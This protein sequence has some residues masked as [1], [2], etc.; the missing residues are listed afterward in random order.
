MPG[1]F[2]TTMRMIVIEDNPADVRLVREALK[3]SG[4]D[5]EVSHFPDGL[6]A[7]A[8]LQSG[9]Q[10]WSPPP[11]IVLLDLNMPRMSGF[12]VLET[13]RGTPE[14]ESTRIVVFT[15]SQ[16]PADMEM[17]SKLRADRFVRKPTELREFFDVVSST[18]RELTG[19]RSN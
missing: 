5:I 7:V 11:E 10:P 1:T 15:S 18:V 9:G 19:P 3:Y 14:F 6:A 12:D 13:L 8:M 17:A 4:I 16:S 2:Y